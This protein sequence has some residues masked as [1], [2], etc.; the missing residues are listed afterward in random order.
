[1]QYF[2][3]QK[4][5]LRG[6]EVL[7][8]LQAERCTRIYAA[9]V[10]S[11]S[12]TGELSRIELIKRGHAASAAGAL[13]G[14]VAALSF[15]PLAVLIGATGGALIG[16]SAELLHEDDAANV[17]KTTSRALDP[18]KAAVVAEIDEH[19]STELAARMERVGGSV[20]RK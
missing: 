2:Q 3:T 14:G 17:A 6:A 7:R 4:N 16:Y 11:R 8:N 5:A 20:L 18:G 12:V 10:I 9:A 1:L 13:I 19:G 15:G